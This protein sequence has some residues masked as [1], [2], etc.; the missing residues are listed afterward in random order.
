[1]IQNVAVIGFG[2]MGKG[3]ALVFAQFAIMLNLLILTRIF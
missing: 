3:I 1:M 2:T